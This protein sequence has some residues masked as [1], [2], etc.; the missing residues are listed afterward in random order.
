MV[1][2]ITIQFSD[3][4]KLEDLVNQFK[5]KLN[6]LEL[7]NKNIENLDNELILGWLENG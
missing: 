4:D 6:E 5:I 2:I 7:V 3:N 1:V